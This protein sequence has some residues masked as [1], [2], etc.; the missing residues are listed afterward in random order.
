MFVHEFMIL[1]QLT[2]KNLIKFFSH[3]YLILILRKTMCYL[4]NTQLHTEQLNN[5]LK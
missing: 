4:T 1:T 3:T 5:I 2:Y